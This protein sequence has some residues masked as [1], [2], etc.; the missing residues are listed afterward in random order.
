[1]PISVSGLVKTF[2]RTRALDGLDLDVRA[3]EVH[4]FLG[5]NGAGQVDHHPGPAR[6]A[7]GRRGR[8]PGCSAATRGATPSTLH[9][10]LAYV[11]GDVTLWPNLTGGEVDRPARPAARRA[12]PDAPGRAARAL[13]ARPDARRAGPTPRATGRRSRWSPRSP[14]TSSCS[15]STSRRP[16]LDPL[17]EEVFQRVRRGGAR[18]GPHR[19]AVQ[20]HPGR[21]RGAVRPGEHHPRGPHGRD[22]HA[23]RAAAPDP[24][25]DHGRAGRARRTGWPTL[26]G[27]HDLP[28]STATGC[29]FEVDTDELDAVLRAPRPSRASAA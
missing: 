2:G 29:S 7:A 21:G 11:P 22:R 26:P 16:G 6:P 13:R 4:G 25:L 15:S 12:R 27:V 5:P 14:P 18:R 28:R 20:P 23:R 9:R 24:H 17:M 10:R 1:M 19:A 3:G 8:R